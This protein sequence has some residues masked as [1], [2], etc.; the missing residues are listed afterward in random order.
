[1]RLELTRRGDYAIRAM[2]ALARAE[3]PS[4]RGRPSGDGLLSV[5]RIAATQAIPPRILPSVM[6]LLMQARLVEAQ[7]GRTGGYCLARRADRISLLD[8]IEAVEGDIRRQSCI[9]RGGPCL[10]N[11]VCAV[12]GVF[13]SAEAAL[14][15]SLAAAT[16]AGAAAA[17]SGTMPP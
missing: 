17:Q 6:R 16:L 10:A 9:L 13:A 2:L 4:P 7:M 5:S 11:G 14:R 1:M 15:D 8:I 3:G 12:H